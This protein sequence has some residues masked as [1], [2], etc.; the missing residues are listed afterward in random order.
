MIY[1]FQFTHWQKYIFDAL[2]HFIPEYLLI[3]GILF[4]LFLIPF[5]NFYSLAPYLAFITLIITSFFVPNSTK[6]FFNG[7]IAHSYFYTKVTYI[8][9][10]GTLITIVFSSLSLK[11]ILQPEYYIFLL[12]GQLG[13]QVIAFSRNWLLS[14]VAF[15]LVS[16]VGYFLTLTLKENKTASVSAVKYFIYGAFSSGVMLYGISLL[17]GVYGNLSFGNE[18]KSLGIENVALGLILVGIFF[19]LTIVPLHFWA[20]EVY[21]GVTAPVGAWLTTVSKMAGISFFYAF[22]S[23]KVLSFILSFLWGISAVTMFIGNIGILR[24]KNI[25]RLM[26]FSSIAHSGFLFMVMIIQEPY[27]SSAV[28]FYVLFSIPI[29]FL[30]FYAL[31][32]FLQ[33]TQNED[34]T[35]WNGLGKNYPWLAFILVL[36]LAGLIGL[37]PT[38]GFIAKLNLAIAVWNEYLRSHNLFSLFCLIAFVLNTLFAFAAYSRIPIILLL[39]TSPKELSTKI[40]Y[41]GFFTVPLVSLII[42]FGVYG[43]DKILQWLL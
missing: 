39:R 40:S 16:F 4:L 15:E 9:L 38:I 42:I 10:L 23:M 35:E 11:N 7:T 41:H 24:Q 33:I 30:V 37:P 36:G 29:N 19:K 3:S 17:Y 27:A 43:F 5:R 2:P 26:G 12:A 6:E 31:H 25:F 14:F 8:S 28:W 34:F 32:Q 18:W 1:L 13:I 22:Y 21:Q 20:P